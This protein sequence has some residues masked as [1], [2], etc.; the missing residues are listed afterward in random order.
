MLNHSHWA[1][2][3][4]AIL[5]PN[6]MI[7]Y[8]LFYIRPGKFLQNLF[9]TFWKSLPWLDNRKLCGENVKLI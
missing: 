3:I 9:F 6:F 1:F 4:P 8:H 7:I 2:I 5:T